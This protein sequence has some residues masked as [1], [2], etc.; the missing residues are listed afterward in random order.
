MVGK[1]RISNR[2]IFSMFFL[3]SVSVSAK[4]NKPAPVLTLRDINGR[5]V[6][7]PK[8]LEKGPVIIW[9]WNSCCGIKK[10]QVQSL[11]K[12]YEKYKE[13]GLQVIAISEDGVNKTSKTKQAVKVYKM[14][15]IVVMDN[16][17]NLMGKFQAYAVPSLYVITPD[18]KIVFTHSGYMPGDE[19]KL[20]QAL[21]PL[22]KESKPEKNT[23]KTT[24]SEK[25]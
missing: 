18:N 1:I 20:E 9:F 16:S 15:F 13:K 7:S 25:G 8:L 4:D 21:A 19:K 17:R 24:E 23:E 14:P 2:F 5:T 10:P 12:I 6:N 22:F 11:K 3:V